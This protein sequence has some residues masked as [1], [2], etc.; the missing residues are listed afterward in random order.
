MFSKNFSLQCNWLMH[1]SNVFL[2]GI[3]R[4]EH[5]HQWR[6][7]LW[8]WI[9]SKCLYQCLQSTDISVKSIISLSNATFL[10]LRH[11]NIVHLWMVS[12][13]VG[14][15][16]RR[17]NTIY[18]TYRMLFK[19]ELLS[20]NNNNNYS[21]EQLESSFLTKNYLISHPDENNMHTSSPH[22]NSNL[23]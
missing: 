18:T 17:Q 3:S 11:D 23:T 12:V 2:N 8:Y 7:I 9:C 15:T 4:V 21:S 16:Q 22:S 10:D 19:Y 6:W 5:D 1:T 14:S 20:W 13:S